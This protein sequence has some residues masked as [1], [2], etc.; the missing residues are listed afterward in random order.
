MYLVALDDFGVYDRGRVVLRVNAVKNRVA[1]NALAQVAVAVRPA[2]ALGD[3][4]L[5]VA[6]DADL[7]A[8]LDKEHSHARVLTE[9]YLLLGGD[10]VV[11][12]YL[13]EHAF[14]DG[15]FLVV[16]R[17]PERTENIRS[18]KIIAVHKQLFHSRG[19]LL[20]GNSAEV[21]IIIPFRIHSLF[22]YKLFLKLF[23][24]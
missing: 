20:S 12:D 22:Y 14:A 2:Y 17:L 18:D 24:Y 23:Q 3:S 11:L 1:D 19:D 6:V 9:R 7:V 5:K 15:R 10:A 13:R 4:L 8:V 21:H 16:A